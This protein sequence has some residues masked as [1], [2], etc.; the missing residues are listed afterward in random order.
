MRR[1]RRFIA[2][3]YMF[4]FGGGAPP[5]ISGMAEATAIQAL[6]RAAVLLEEPAY[7]RDRP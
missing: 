4:H 5:W 7:H 6:A 3:E 2:W 1:S